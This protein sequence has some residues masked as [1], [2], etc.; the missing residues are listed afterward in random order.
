MMTRKA[1]LAMFTTAVIAKPAEIDGDF[2]QLWNDFAKPMTEYVNGLR[3]GYNRFDKLREGVRAWR[4][5]ERAMKW[6]ESDECK[7]QRLF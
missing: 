2:I 5:L 1:L 7:N 3:G 6:T 4:K